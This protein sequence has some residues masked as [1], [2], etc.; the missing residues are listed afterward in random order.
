MGLAKAE[1]R[2]PYLLD[3]YPL[4]GEEHTRIYPFFDHL[5]EGRLTTTRCVACGEV[6]WQP[7]VVCP[8]CNGDEM[9]WIDLPQ[10]GEIFAF[11]SVRLGAPTGME[12]DLPFVIGIVTLKGADLQI[13]ARIDGDEESLRIG[14]PVRVAVDHLPDGRVWFRFRSAEASA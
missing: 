9:E 12:D 5:R 6:L 13:L 1:D 4:Q 7:R 11:T 3:F 2:V 8:H 14:Q 10:E